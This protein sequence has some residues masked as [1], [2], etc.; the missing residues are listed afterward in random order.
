MKSFYFM[1]LIAV[2]SFIT[3]CES[4]KSKIRKTMEQMQSA[5]IV[6]PYDKLDCWTSD[7]IKEISPW[8]NAKLKLVHYID[9][10]QCSS[11]YL[12]KKQALEPLI[13]LEKKSNNQFCNL[14]IV[15]PGVNSRNWKVLTENY[16][17]KA[18][19]T[20]LFIDSIN[21]F[22]NENPNIPQESMYHTFL[23]DENNKVILIGN[24]ILNKQIEEM[25]L[26]IVEE[27]LGKVIST[28]N[29]QQTE[30]AENP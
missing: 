3:A 22:M 19:P 8:K 1:F 10:A 15:Q 2:C 4:N 7:S 12:V 20:T 18:T 23:L 25:L 24:P 29:N 30:E 14:F 27:K 28:V 6:I 5:Q 11:C 13:K 16:K 9:S 17:H 21:V 26:P